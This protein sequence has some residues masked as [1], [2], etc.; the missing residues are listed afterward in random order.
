MYPALLECSVACALGS[1]DTPVLKIHVNTRL[2]TTCRPG[3]TSFSPL[4]GQANPFIPS[5]NIFM[6]TTRAYNEITFMVSIAAQLVYFP[7]LVLFS[8]AFVSHIYFWVES[9]LRLPDV[10]VL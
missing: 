2:A 7:V 4:N 9:E 6:P 1:H 3:Y 8:C 5:A 10:A